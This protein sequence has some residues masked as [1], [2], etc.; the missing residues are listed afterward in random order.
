MARRKAGVFERFDGGLS[1]I[2]VLSLLF[3]LTWPY[4]RVSGQCRL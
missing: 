3:A 4:C 1:A 2:V